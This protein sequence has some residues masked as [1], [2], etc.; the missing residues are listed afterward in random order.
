MAT[1]TVLFQVRYA[2]RSFNLARSTNP[3]N[4]FLVPPGR[5]G[6]QTK[7]IHELQPWPWSKKFLPVQDACAKFIFC[8]GECNIFSSYTTFGKGA[9]FLFS[10]TTKIAT[11]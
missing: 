10:T 8:E 11:I 2:T 6:Q 4:P 1:A 9:L 5:P 3:L 7:V